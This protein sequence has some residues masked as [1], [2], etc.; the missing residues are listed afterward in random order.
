M[1][2]EVVDRLVDLARRAP[3]AGHTQ[4]WA[5]VVLEGHEQTGRFWSTDADPAWLAQPDHP[6]VLGR[7]CW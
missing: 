6:G 5:F 3:S 4:G 2:P 7:R 1:P